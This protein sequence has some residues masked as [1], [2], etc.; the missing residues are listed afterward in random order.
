MLLQTSAV[1]PHC[2]FGSC[3]ASEMFSSVDRGLCQGELPSFRSITSCSE[4]WPQQGFL[5]LARG[6]RGPR[7]CD[8]LRRRRLKNG[9][10]LLSQQIIRSAS[11]KATMAQM[12]HLIYLF[13]YLFRFSWFDDITGGSGLQS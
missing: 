5:E 1:L 10:A 6:H 3:I 8:D 12:A 9:A 2:K 11:F 4:T 7:S 13:V